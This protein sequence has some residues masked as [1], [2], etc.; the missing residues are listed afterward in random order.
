MPE[1]TRFM[2]KH[3]VTGKMLLD[4]DG[5]PVKYTLDPLPNDGWRFTVNE[6]DHSQVEPILELQSELNVFL[7]ET[8]DDQ[9]IVKNW[10]YVKSGGVEYDSSQRSLT[11]TA[12]SRIRYLPSDYYE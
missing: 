6:L 5:Q 2:V 1:H 11:I 4:S 9:P 12:D 10:Y 7:F 8:S 3:A